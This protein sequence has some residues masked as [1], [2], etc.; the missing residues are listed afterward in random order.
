MKVIDETRI[1]DDK[2][3]RSIVICT[4]KEKL[5]IDISKG[6]IRVRS[7]LSVQNLSDDLRREEKK[8]S[9]SGFFS[10]DKDDSKTFKTF[11]DA[12]GV[13]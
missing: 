8:S 13:W 9:S 5:I 1:I 12:S 6:N 10:K 3:N 2:D 11:R 4:S 7:G